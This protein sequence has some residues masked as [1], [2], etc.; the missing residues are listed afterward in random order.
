MTIILMLRRLALAMLL[1]ASLGTAIAG[2]VDEYDIDALVSAGKVDVQAL[3]NHGPEVMPVLV[4]IYER[5]GPDKRAVIARVFY[6]LGWKSPRAEAVL[7]PDVR[8]SH[9]QLRLQVQWALGRVSDDPA[10]VDALLNTMRHDSNPLFRDKAACA[11]AYDQIRRPRAFVPGPQ[12]WNARTPSASGNLGWTNTATTCS[13]RRRCAAHGCH[14]W[15][16]HTG[17]IQ[18]RR[19]CSRYR[20][21]YLYGIRACEGPRKPE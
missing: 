1:G 15:A 5:S 12:R 3:K 4:S 19:R 6:Q 17:G 14:A 2:Y 13:R 8:T 10:V 18:F 21:R 9:K 11:L 7:M 20:S 16:E